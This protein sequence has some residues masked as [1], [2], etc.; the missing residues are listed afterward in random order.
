MKTLE[1]SILAAVA[2][3]AFGALALMAGAGKAADDKGDIRDSVQKVA[4]TLEKG[5][6]EAAKK[7]AGDIAKA[8]ELEEV[9]N[10]MQLRKPAAKKP[11]FGYGETPGVSKPDGIEAKLTG[12]GKRVTKEQLDKESTDVLKLAYR[13]AAIAEIAKQK[14]PEKNQPGKTKVEWTQWAEAMSKSAKDLA[15]AAKEKNPATVKT[16]AAKLNNACTSCHGIFRD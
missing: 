14:P 12:L 3:A 8:N 2:F 11:A 4:D 10:L 5:D 6:A 13:V 16:A 7:V 9:M 15:D 1:H